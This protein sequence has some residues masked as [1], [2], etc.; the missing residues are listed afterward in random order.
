MNKTGIGRI[1]RV[2]SPVEAVVRPAKTRFGRDVVDEEYVKAANWVSA[3]A[4]VKLIENGHLH[5]WRVCDECANYDRYLKR[6]L[7]L[8]KGTTGRSSCGFWRDV[9]G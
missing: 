7:I 1:H 2:A 3:D 6:C 9:A 8:R 4:A 5:A